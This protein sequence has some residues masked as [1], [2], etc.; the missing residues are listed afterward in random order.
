MDKPRILNCR[1][2]GELS[3][4]YIEKLIKKNINKTY[5]RFYSSI[6]WNL[7]QGAL[8]RIFRSCGSVQNVDIVKHPGA[9]TEETTS[10]VIPPG[11]VKVGSMSEDEIIQIHFVSR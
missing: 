11:I 2:A 8:K 6:V 1:G 9:Q 10:L 4:I 3:D 5:S 7:S